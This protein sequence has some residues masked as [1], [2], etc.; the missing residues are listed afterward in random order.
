MVVIN[1]LLWQFLC[2]N[3]MHFFTRDLLAL[4]LFISR[5]SSRFPVVSASCYTFLLFFSRI[6]LLKKRQF[7]SKIYF[8][9]I[10]N[11]YYYL[12]LHRSYDFFARNPIV[13]NCS[14]NWV[15][16]T[17]GN[18]FQF[19]KYTHSVSRIFSFVSFLKSVV[20]TENKNSISLRYSLLFT[21][22][23]YNLTRIYKSFLL[24]N[25]IQLRRLT[26]SDLTRYP[27]IINLFT[28]NCIRSKLF[29]VRQLTKYITLFQSLQPVITKNISLTNNITVPALIRRLTNFRLTYFQ[30]NLSY[31]LQQLLPFSIYPPRVQFSLLNL[32]TFKSD[33]LFQKF[34]P[35]AFI[36]VRAILKF[37]SLK[38]I[39]SVQ[40]FGPFIF[41]LFY[42]YS[43][44]LKRSHLVLREKFFF[45]SYLFFKIFRQVLEIL[46]NFFI[47]VF[48]KFQFFFQFC[49]HFLFYFEIL[50]LYALL[51]SFSLFFKSVLLT[52][53]KVR[54][55]ST[56]GRTVV[57]RH[58]ASI[59][60]EHRPI[61]RRVFISFFF[62]VLYRSLD[63][64][65]STLTYGYYKARASMRYLK[66]MEHFFRYVVSPAGEHFFP[67]VEGIKFIVR[68]KHRV[69][70]R[71]KQR[72]FSTGYF[73]PR[74]TLHYNLLYAFEESYSYRGVMGFHIWI[75]FREVTA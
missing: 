71:N 61:F 7:L 16:K 56:M 6:L 75:K 3:V 52:R 69:A 15:L 9:K 22:I 49:S 44:L 43:I 32:G 39:Q 60:F 67:G 23:R 46:Y 64:F 63:S 59:P 11:L 47:S 65:M 73:I 40:H 12:Y 50:N 10:I 19:K 41:R 25:L 35:N 54:R 29:V 38:Y 58:S 26:K 24:L 14:F 62:S 31:K 33:L 74:Q 34:S 70:E 5:V 48:W 53:A 42:K 57:N 37:W 36:R 21:Y 51:F 66:Q 1:N 27:S 4:W 18:F 45:I 2:Y 30:H 8:K 68:G 17:K 72:F 20:L 28:K 13:T 55:L